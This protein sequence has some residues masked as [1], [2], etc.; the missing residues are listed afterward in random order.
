MLSIVFSS[1]CKK[2]LCEKYGLLFPEHIQQDLVLA[3]CNLN[4]GAM[5][6][7]EDSLGLGFV[8]EGEVLPVAGRT[9]LIDTIL[10]TV[11]AKH[12]SAIEELIGRRTFARQ[13]VGLH[14]AWQER[15]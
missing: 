10:E 7:R 8:H 13:A 6:G 14:V 2:D 11:I 12:P 9:K 5:P 3:V 4:D 1:L 15:P